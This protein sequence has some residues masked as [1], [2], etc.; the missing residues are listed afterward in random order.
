MNTRILHR[1]TFHQSN[2]SNNNHNPIPTEHIP[3]TIVPQSTRIARGSSRVFSILNVLYTVAMLKHN[4]N[5]KSKRCHPD[6]DTPVVNMLARMV[7]MLHLGD[8]PGVDGQRNLNNHPQPAH[9]E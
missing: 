7:I 2:T 9:P 3:T 6:K 5:I 8:I 4:G 1:D